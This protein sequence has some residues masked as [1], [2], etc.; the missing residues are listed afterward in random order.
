MNTLGQ[1]DP[2]GVDFF[3]R[4]LRCRQKVESTGG[5]LRCAGLTITVGTV[6]EL[7]VYPYPFDGGPILPFGRSAP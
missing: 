5:C 1:A 2:P 4:C 3:G 6:I 7:P